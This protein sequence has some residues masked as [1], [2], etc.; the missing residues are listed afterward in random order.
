MSSSAEPASAAQEQEQEQEQA[1]ASRRRVV[2]T[3]AAGLVG[4]AVVARLTDDGHEVVQFDQRPTGY[5]KSIVGDVTDAVELVEALWGADAVVHL[6]GVPGSNLDTARRTLV[7]NVVGTYNVFQLAVRL[8]ILRVVWASSEG[9]FGVPFSAAPPAYLPVD[10][11]H[12]RTPRTAYGVSKALCE[13][14]ADICAEW[15][16]T[17]FVGLRFVHVMDDQALAELDEYRGSPEDKVW[18][19]WSYVHVA[20]AADAVARALA[21][22]VSGTAN[23][24]ISADD[25]V[26]P[27]PTRE[28]AEASFGD[29]TPLGDELDGLS[30]AFSGARAA[31]VLGFRPK[32][33]WRDK[34]DSR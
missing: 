13:Q 11:D 12:P 14:L 3:G 1:A 20:D 24:L 34:G 26:M 8:G 28:L 17:T 15:G 4:R 9:V 29:A 23:F 18:D 5:G 21:V 22:D 19:L 32:H 30:A 10:D 27:T 25:T 2:V 31:T 33:S 7:T 6:A 16:D